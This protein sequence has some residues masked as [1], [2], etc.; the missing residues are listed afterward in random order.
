MESILIIL[1]NKQSDW[2][3]D[4]Q[5]LCGYAAWLSLSPG[6]TGLGSRA[7]NNKI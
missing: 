1:N 7:E 4:L 5:L 3:D 2:V 6:I